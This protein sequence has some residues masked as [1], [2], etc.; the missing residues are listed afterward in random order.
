LAGAVGVA[1]CVAWALWGQRGLGLGLGAEVRMSPAGAVALVFLSAGLWLRRS[2]GH[3]RAGAGLALAVVAYAVVNLAGH[4]GGWIAAWPPDARLSPMGA[5]ALAALGGAVAGLD[6]RTPGGGQP[7]HALAV[8]AA[9]LAVLA[10]LAHL[11]DVAAVVELGWAHGLAPHSAFAIGLLALGV[12]LARRGPGALQILAG[13]GEGGRLARRLLPL[14]VLVPPGLDALRLAL[15]PAVPEMRG[16]VDLGQAVQTTLVIFLLTGFVW[17]GLARADASDRRTREAEEAARASE[18]QVRE[19]VESLP[20]LVWTCAP[21]GPCDYLSPQWIRYTGRPAEGQLGLGWLEQVHPDDRE[22]V[23]K[24]WGETALAGRS[25]DVEFRIRRHDGEYRWFK[26]R[27]EPLRDRRGRIVKWFGTNTDIEDQ[28]RAER[29][30]REAHDELERRVRERTAELEALSLRARADAATAREAEQKL[31][32]SENLL[33]DFVRHVPAAIAMFDR[34]MR[35]LRASERWAADFRLGD[36][37]LVGRSHY[38]VFPNLPEHWRAVHRRVLAGAVERAEEESFRLADGRLEWLQWEARPWRGPDGEVSGLLLFA[39]IITER[40]RL[41]M[42]LEARREEL[43]RSNR[44]LEQFAYVAS[45]DLQEPLRAVAGCLQLLLRRHG[46]RMEPSAHE[47]VAHAVDGARRMQGLILDLLT[48][49]RVGTGELLRAPTRLDDPLSEALANLSAAIAETGAEV[50]QDASLPVLEV[51][52][53]RV[54]MLLQ[55]LVG[56]AIKYRSPGR[57]PRI[58]VGAERRPEGVVVSVRDNG[59][60]IEPRFHDRIF[61]IFQR[62]HTRGEYPGSGIGL[63]LC[64][65][66][67]E[68]HG[69]RIWVESSPGQ[70]SIFRFT[71]AP[72]GSP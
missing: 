9:M 65:K 18:R 17:R 55:N 33:S 63:A 62:L 38:D 61:V 52:R 8:F 70:G 13:D 14:V 24:L 43:Q 21:E 49:S 44:D 56:N 57:A 71:L 69:G 54:V 30:L 36:I 68:R 4:L 64:K 40:K 22:R 5:A 31:R 15:D 72:P 11:Y 1:V 39:Q 32:T 34:D 23:A 20:Q 25:F 48:Y 58:H 53:A 51:D 6:L 41:Q 50:T 37:E 28:R 59:I 19:L 42:D 67:V 29:R 66:I 35:Y 10:A 47:L 46:E 7:T 16:G 26:T 12:L 27:A 45:H 2:G 60:G 3:G